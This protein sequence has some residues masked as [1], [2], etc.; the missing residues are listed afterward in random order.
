M[1]N[2]QIKCKSCGNVIGYYKDTD[3]SDVVGDIKLTRAEIVET[4]MTTQREMTNPKA[5]VDKFKYEMVTRC[6]Y[7]GK[8][9]M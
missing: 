9:W 8:R 6:D 5:K 3:I 1:T 2:K 7:C 4:H